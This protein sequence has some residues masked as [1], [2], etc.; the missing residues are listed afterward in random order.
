MAKPTT[1][2]PSPAVTVQKTPPKPV[3]WAITAITAIGGVAIATFFAIHYQSELGDTRAMLTGANKNLADAEH[4]NSRLK[5]V[6]DYQKARLE[7]P[8]RRMTNAASYIICPDP[9]NPAEQIIFGIRGYWNES[10]TALG[11]VFLVRGRPMQDAYVVVQGQKPQS[12]SWME[13]ISP[14]EAMTTLGLSRVQSLL[15]KV[16]ADPDS[17]SIVQFPTFQ[18]QAR[19]ML[20]QILTVP[21]DQLDRA[22]PPVT[23][24]AESMPLIVQPIQ[25]EPQWRPLPKS[26]RGFQPQDDGQEP[27]DPAKPFSLLPGKSQSVPVCVL[28]E[29]SG[30]YRRRA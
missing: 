3:G 10:Q 26:K 6:I 16:T 14:Y 5:L 25:P 27:K 21:A 12:L 19:A 7:Q 4:E 22:R 24:T 15:G 2:K 18:A 20:Q 9:T 17:L 8:L 1:S 28:A 13:P 30:S 29:I 23:S 11:G